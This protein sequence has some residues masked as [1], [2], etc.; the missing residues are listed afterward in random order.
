[1]AVVDW[2]QVDRLVGS[3]HV[4]RNGSHI[5]LTPRGRLLLDHILGAI[6]APENLGSARVLAVG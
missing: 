3:G 2:R 5:A 6:A 1:V 4:A